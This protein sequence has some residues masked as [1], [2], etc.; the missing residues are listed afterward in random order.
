MNRRNKPYTGKTQINGHDFQFSVIN[1]KGTELDRTEIYLM[2]GKPGNQTPKKI[3][4]FKI[5]AV[6][7]L[8]QHR[9]WFLN[10]L[11]AHEGVQD[12]VAEKKTVLTTED[13]QTKEQA[14]SEKDLEKEKQKM[15]KEEEDRKARDL[16]DQNKAQESAEEAK[17]EAAKSD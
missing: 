5:G 4:E 13:Q 8:G 16:E 17:E 3:D 2:K 1:G 7:T 6:L 9:E 10:A 14:K 15:A 11:N 12:I